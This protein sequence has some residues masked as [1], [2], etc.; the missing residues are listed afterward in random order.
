MAKQRTRVMATPRSS[1]GP[2]AELKASLVII[3]G[4]NAGKVFAIPGVKACIGRE[5]GVEIHVDDEAMSRTHAAIT[6]EGSEYRI[7]DL[8]SSNGT[9][10][11][12]SKVTEYA[13]RNGDKLMV[14]ETLF[15][16][17]VEDLRE[18]T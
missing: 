14:G 12:G 17:R 10:L 1:G 9:W 7:R 2:P 4:P 5:E 15:V 13:L 3:E 11:N 6:W 18:H 8:G 16:F